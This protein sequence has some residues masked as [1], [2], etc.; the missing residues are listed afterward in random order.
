ML[1]KKKTPLFFLITFFLVVFV[2]ISHRKTALAFIPNDPDYA[3]QSYL[4]RVNAPLAWDLVDRHRLQRDV[5]VA[6]LDTGV[7]IDH[8]DLSANIWKNSDE[9]PGDGIDND[10]NTY[11][12][13]VSGWDF[14]ESSADPRPKLSSSSSYEAVH[15]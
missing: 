8:P 6:L 11:I 3:R 15:H 12:D 10:H 2:F 1:A 9:I 14:I 4:T 5:V 7:D 13:D